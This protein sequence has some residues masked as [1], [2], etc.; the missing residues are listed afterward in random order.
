MVGVGRRRWGLRGTGEATTGGDVAFEPEW[1]VKGWH[2]EWEVG[3]VW[4]S[5]VG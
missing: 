1:L 5:R 2:E 4:A 3:V